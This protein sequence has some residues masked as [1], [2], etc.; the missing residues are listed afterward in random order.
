[1]K[2]DKVISREYEL[3]LKAENFT[4]NEPDLIKKGVYIPGKL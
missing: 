1:M 4:G 2:Q 3:V